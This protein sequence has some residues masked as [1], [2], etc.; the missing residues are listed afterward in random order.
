MK[1][2]TA[3][4]EVHHDASPN[5]GEGRNGESQDHWA[6]QW[7]HVPTFELQD[8]DHILEFHQD[9]TISSSDLLNAIKRIVDRRIVRQ[10]GFRDAFKDCCRTYGDVWST[11]VT[12]PGS[13]NERY[14][15]WLDAGDSS[16]P[17]PSAREDEAT[18]RETRPQHDFPMHAPMARNTGTYH[19]Y[20]DIGTSSDGAL[21]F[22]DVSLQVICE[23]GE[24]LNVSP[25]FFAYHVCSPPWWRCDSS[26]R[27]Q[28][29][30]WGLE[31]QQCSQADGIVYETYGS[32]RYI[33]FNDVLPSSFVEVD[34]TTHT[35]VSCLN[36]NEAFYIVLL[37]NAGS[38]QPFE[39]WEGALVLPMQGELSKLSDLLYGYF[40]NAWSVQRLSH[41][42]KHGSS[43]EQ[44]SSLF[45][46]QLTVCHYAQTLSSTLRKVEGPLAGVNTDEA[47][48][49][50]K[51]YRNSVARLRRHLANTVGTLDP[52]LLQS[53]Y[54][55]V[56]TCSDHLDANSG[57][58]SRV[59]SSYQSPRQLVSRT[60]EEEHNWL[61]R[62]AAHVMSSL[63]ENL[64]LIIAAISLKQSRI[65]LEDSRTSRR[66]GELATLLT[67]LAAIYLPMTL[68][69][70][71]FGMNIQEINGEAKGPNWRAVAAVAGLLLGASV[72]SIA[73]FWLWPKRKRSSDLGHE[74][75]APW[76][77]AAEGFYVF[78]DDIE[79][80]TI[81]ELVAA[82]QKSKWWRL[83]KLRQF[84]VRSKKRKRP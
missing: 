57:A 44:N 59:S 40:S 24:H 2:T 53:V 54:D 33:A 72:L 74:P 77:Q 27:A 81:A 31:S 80:G 3:D 42:L 62:Q 18:W 68:A 60:L 12:P 37:K 64:Q 76:E 34:P 5:G 17:I 84:K 48:G 83:P 36:V 30:G 11:K 58:E 28:R 55:K 29:S 23:V 70:G 25:S 15:R 13:Q 1:L 69:T 32:R 65:A 14:E 66:N 22:V 43:L 41:L 10:R 52:R 19:P 63:N 75:E 20:C 39:P 4:S 7:Q 79:L 56:A 47:L 35:R 51:G 49:R 71:I 9:E 50:L 46:W 16:I 78:P 8:R 61:E 67:L 6:H 45:I 21:M 82:G 26:A 38:A 73:V